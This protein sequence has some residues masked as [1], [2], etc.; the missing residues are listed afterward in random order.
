M[1]IQE[2]KGFKK[3]IK[4]EPYH[5]AVS[6]GLQESDG[7]SYESPGKHSITSG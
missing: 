3:Y 2:T 4:K 7:L 6:K 5:T 1:H